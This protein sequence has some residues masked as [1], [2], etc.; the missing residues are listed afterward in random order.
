MEHVN[1][2]MERSMENGKKS[3]STIVIYNEHIYGKWSFIM[4]I[5][6]EN[7]HFILEKSMES[8]HL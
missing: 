3:L 4:D 5:S 2:I 8:C 7:C 1:F 6:M